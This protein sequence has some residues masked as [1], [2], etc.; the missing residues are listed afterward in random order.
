[1]LDLNFLSKRYFY[2]D[3]PVEYKIGEDT[4][5]IY[6]ISLID[7]EVFLASCDILCINKN[8]IPSVEIIQMSYLEF[9]MKAVLENEIGRYKLQVILK[10]CLHYEKPRVVSKDGKYYIVDDEAKVWINSQQFEDIR[11]II[12]YQNIIEYDDSYV[13]SDLKKAMEETDAMRAKNIDFPTIERK[14]AIITA[15]CGLSKTEQLNM[16]YRSHCLLFKEVSGEVDFTT[17]RAVAL[18]GG[19]GKELDHW[20]YKKKSGKFD[21]YVTELKQYAGKFGAEKLNT[22]VSPSNA[23]DRSFENFSKKF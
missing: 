12:M 18:F 5:Y 3:L 8:M 19:K 14:I 6:P 23:Y 17:T 13:D 9:L 2:F 1:M 21:E 16:T 20:I 10:Y 4:V 11:R 22:T 7:S 15:H